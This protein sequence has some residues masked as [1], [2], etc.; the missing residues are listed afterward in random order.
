L[1][2]PAG[3]VVFWRKGDKRGASDYVS[4]AMPLTVFGSLSLLKLCRAGRGDEHL[5]ETA[6]TR[7]RASLIAKICKWLGIAKTT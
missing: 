3:D 5:G 4:T 2:A 6:Q 1:E 7:H